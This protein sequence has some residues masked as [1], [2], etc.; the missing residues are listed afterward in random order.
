MF[1]GWTTPGQIRPRLKHPFADVPKKRN[2]R[3]YSIFCTSRSYCIDINRYSGFCDLKEICI[4]KYIFTLFCVT[5]LYKGI[6]LCYFTTLLKIF[7]VQ[8]SG[9]P[10][11]PSYVGSQG[12]RTV[13]S[14]PAYTTEKSLGPKT[15]Q[16]MNV[17]LVWLLTR[18]R[19]L[20]HC[21]RG[22]QCF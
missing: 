1:E 22:W 5:E 12:R 13:S 15:E 16:I 21:C 14:C 6:S 7:L 10:C 4:F 19:E 2:S 17:F 11:D 20:S 8:H 3:Q 9:L 18:Q